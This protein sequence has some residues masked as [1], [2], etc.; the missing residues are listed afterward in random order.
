MRANSY[1]ADKLYVLYLDAK[2]A[3]IDYGIVFSSECLLDVI[4]RSFQ[5]QIRIPL[6]I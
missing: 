1:Q 3:I 5:S 2:Q 4:V 6:D